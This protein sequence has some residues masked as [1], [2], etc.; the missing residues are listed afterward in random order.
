[1]SEREPDATP[2]DQTPGEEAPEEDLIEINGK[3]YHRPQGTAAR[4][5]FTDENGEP[6][7][8]ILIPTEPWYPNLSQEEI[9]RRADLA[10]QR[11]TEIAT[12]I[13]PEF[14]AKTA[15]GLRNSGLFEGMAQQLIEAVQTITVEASRSEGPEVIPLADD[16]TDDEIE[17][18]AIR[19]QAILHEEL[20][21]AIRAS[22]VEEDTA[23]EFQEGF[24]FDVYSEAYFRAVY[25][26]EEEGGNLDQEGAFAAFFDKRAGDFTTPAMLDAIADTQASL[27]DLIAS[28][29]KEQ[30]EPQIKTA[31]EKRF[32]RRRRRSRGRR[33]TPPAYVAVP[34]QMLIYDLGRALASSTGW[35]VREGSP[36]PV[37]PIKRGV[38]AGEIAL[39]PTALD[40][41]LYPTPEAQAQY[42]RQMI[43]VRDSLNPLATYVNDVMAAEYLKQTN[44]PGEAA[45]LRVDDILEKQGLK[46]HKGGSG[47]RGGY[48]AEQRRETLQA[49]SQVGSVWFVVEGAPTIEEKPGGKRQKTTVDVAGSRLFT[50]TDWRGKRNIFDGEVDIQEITFR[51]GEGVARYFHGAGRWTALQAAALARYNFSREKPEYLLARYL[52]LQWRIDSQ[53]GNAPKPFRI[54]TILQEADLPLDKR[55]PSRTQERIEKALDRL[56]TDEHIAGWQYREGDADRLEEIA[57]RVGWAQEW[58]G[59][60]VLI[61]C[62][63]AIRDY[64]AEK[65][66]RP[67]K[68]ARAITAAASRS[69]LAERLR[70]TR[71]S[72]GG[73]TQLQ[74]A[75]QAGIAQQTYSRAESGKGVN[76]QNRRKLE[77]WLHSLNK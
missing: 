51:P 14:L 3:Q 29:V 55:N 44:N 16:V 23:R 75:E 56:Q 74:A 68:K 58:L 69:P 39:R 7:G 26:F 49:I 31:L 73:I 60:V 76:A 77:A 2:E 40:V 25:A 33:S 48:T 43:E 9:L 11:Y 5:D 41:D 65:I 34:S 67:Q 1:M 32:K 37:K 10:Y 61:E 57:G 70:A 42:A 20:E 22:I 6:A 35:E 45:T 21:R 13:G 38:M 36:W 64:Y 27:A 17:S 50:I 59:L 71:Q 4:V 19:T 52:F 18:E 72:L 47:R 28:T 54:E 62:P 15:A 30:I 53:H 12:W 66:E 8:S 24:V 63:D 46:R